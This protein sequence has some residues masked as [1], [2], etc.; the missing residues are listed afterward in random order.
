MIVAG[1][2][3]VL[4][5]ATAGYGAVRG[6][7]PPKK[8]LM[9]WQ[10]S[11]FSDLT[12]VDQAIHSAL[13]VAI[14][15]IYL[16]QAQWGYWPIIEDLQ[17]G[18][19]PPFVKDVFWE[20]NGSVVWTL[21]TPLGNDQGAT[22]YHGSGGQADGQS[23]YLVVLS[24]SHAGSTGQVNPASIWMHPDPN[25]PVPEAFRTEMLIREGWREVVPYSGANELERLK[26]RG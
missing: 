22:Y 24:H 9:E 14:Q 12:P 7:E 20:R 26:G 25:A 8:Q 13:F 1:L 2:C 15:D 16:Q 10:R 23:A 6:G 4:A 19:I 17:Y 5:A 11:S 21:G 3:L 18:G